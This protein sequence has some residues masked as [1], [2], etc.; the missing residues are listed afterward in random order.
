M[1]WRPYYKAAA[2]GR[3]GRGA[4]GEAA[5]AEAAAVEGE[6]GG[7][8]GGMRALPMRRSNSAHEAHCRAMRISLP[9]AIEMLQDPMAM[10]SISL[11]IAQVPARNV[12]QAEKSA[13]T[14]PPVSLE[15]QLETYKFEGYACMTHDTNR[16]VRFQAAIK[17]RHRPG[18]SG[19]LVA[20]H[21]EGGLTACV[22]A[23]F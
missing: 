10:P 4:V 21:S 22:R 1:S 13:C 11:M 16:N 12:W 2:G 9:N 14:R 5:L 8:V 17:V 23:C 15:D 20:F 18:G 6:E 3:E 7:G 19:G